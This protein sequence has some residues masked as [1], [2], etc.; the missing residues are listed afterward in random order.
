MVDMV[1]EL[2]KLAFSGV[3]WVLENKEW[4]FSGGGFVVLSYIFRKPLKDHIFNKTTIKAKNKSVAAKKICNSTINIGDN[5][6]D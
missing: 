5:N 1:I 6:K 2:K 4:L 3:A